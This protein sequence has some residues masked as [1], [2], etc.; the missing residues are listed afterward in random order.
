MSRTNKKT[1][2]LDFSATQPAKMPDW[3]TSLFSTEEAIE[4]TRALEETPLPQRVNKSIKKSNTNK[5]TTNTS[6]TDS[7]QQGSSGLQNQITP[8]DSNIS[9]NPTNNNSNNTDTHN[10]NNNNT[11]DNNQLPLTYGSSISGITS[12]KNNLILH[13]LVN[14][15]TKLSTV[16]QTPKPT[17]LNSIHLL[18]ESTTNSRHL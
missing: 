11:S 8:S 2:K 16:H 18:Q 9:L 1:S 3:A 7:D 14:P 13:C 6:N 17:S 10:N 12:Y 5:Q 4:L 15:N